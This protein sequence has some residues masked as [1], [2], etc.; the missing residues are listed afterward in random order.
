[1]KLCEREEAML[2]KLQHPNINRLIGVITNGLVLEYAQF[3]SLAR[4]LEERQVFFQL[5]PVRSLLFF[6]L[7]FIIP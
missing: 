2:N 5:F 3:G 7:S 4:F 1:M 6:G